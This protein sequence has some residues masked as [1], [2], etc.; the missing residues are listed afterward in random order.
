MHGCH[1]EMTN[2]RSVDCQII[3]CRVRGPISN[4]C[5]YNRAGRAEWMNGIYVFDLIEILQHT[6][7]FIKG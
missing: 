3:V 6:N 2:H 5:K 1:K 7:R 4:D